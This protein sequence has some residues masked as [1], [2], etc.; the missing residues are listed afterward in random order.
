MKIKIIIF[1]ISLVTIVLGIIISFNNKNEETVNV[2]AIPI[3]NKTIV[4]DAGHGL[5]DD[6]ESLLH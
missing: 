3:M 1:I 6:G 4:L 2:N 5:P